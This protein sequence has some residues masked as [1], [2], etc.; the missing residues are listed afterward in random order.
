MRKYVIPITT[1]YASVLVQFAVVAVV[2][3]A[4]SRGDAGRY[5]V[6]MGLVLATYFVAGFGLP[7]GVVR[8]APALAATDL[9]AQADS[10]LRRGFRFSIATVPI[11]AVAGGVIV[12]LYVGFNYSALLAAL[13]WASYG[14]IFVSAQMVVAAGKSELGTAM[15]YSAANTGQLVLTV[16]SI[17]LGRLDDLA[18]VLAATVAGTSVA[19]AVCLVIAVRNCGP[20]SGVGQPLGAAWRQGAVIATGRVIQSCF[21][22]SPVWVVGIVLGPSDAALVGLASRLVSAVAAVLAAVR[23]SI[24]PR[25]ARDAAQGNWQAIQRHSSQ[26]ALFTT[27]LAV[28][29]MLVSATVG[30]ELI[31]LVF[32]S[33]YRGAALIVTLMLIGTLGESFGGPVDEVLKMAGHARAVVGVQIVVMTAGFGLQILAARAAGVTG[34]VTVYGLMFVIMYLALIGY[35]WKL[36]RILIVPRLIR[37]ISP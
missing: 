4:L 10:L 14:T 24:R 11:G 26:I 34:L 36:Q 35:L 1:R 2:T 19:A 17:V 9:V 20:S 33:D 37:D 28:F 15:F 13:W 25:L 7:D 31:T 18:T 22:W 29:A 23:F 27:G 3:H 6:V 12:A 8:F 21:L 5:F 32:G 16:P 30:D